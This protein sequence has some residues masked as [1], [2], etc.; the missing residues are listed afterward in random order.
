MTKREKAL[1]DFGFKPVEDPEIIKSC[2]KEDKKVANQVAP[3][4]EALIDWREKSRNEIVA[5]V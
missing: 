4:I 5:Y 1:R 3:I 2:R